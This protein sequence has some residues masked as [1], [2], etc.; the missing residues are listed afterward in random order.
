[1]FI[2]MDL[3]MRLSKTLSTK[4]KKYHYEWPRVLLSIF[5][6]RSNSE[7][8]RWMTKSKLPDSKSLSYDM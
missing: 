1:M 8:E 7:G 2:F 5:K 4:E 6:Y 3:D